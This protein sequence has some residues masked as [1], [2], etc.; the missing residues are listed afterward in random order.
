MFCFVGKCRMSIL[1]PCSTPNGLDFNLCSSHFSSSPHIF[2]RL[3]YGSTDERHLSPGLPSLVPFSA[4]SPEASNGQLPC[5]LQL[6]CQCI[7]K[8]RWQCTQWRWQWLWFLILNYLN[9]SLRFDSGSYFWYRPTKTFTK[10]YTHVCI[11]I[12]TELVWISR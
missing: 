7:K 1:V 11:Y 3:V 9:Y 12:Y 4:D 8:C 6:P 10:Y 2:F 5:S